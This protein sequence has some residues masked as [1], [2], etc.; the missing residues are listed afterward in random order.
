MNQLAF[1]EERCPDCDGFGSQYG[2]D[3]YPCPTCEGTGFVLG[4]NQ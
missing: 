3:G 4:E 2:D 1:T